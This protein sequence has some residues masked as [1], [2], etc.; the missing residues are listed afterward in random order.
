MSDSDGRPHDLN[1]PLCKTFHQSMRLLCLAFDTLGWGQGILRRG[2]RDP[3]EK[4]IQ[5][6]I[7]MEACAKCIY[8]GTIRTTVPSSS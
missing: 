7:G 8:Y 4:M 3:R 2:Q 5:G 1:A 6:S